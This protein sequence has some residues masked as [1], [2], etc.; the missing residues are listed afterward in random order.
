MKK[1]IIWC[2]IAVVQASAMIVPI[3]AYAQTSTAYSGLAAINQIIQGAY[4][5]AATSVAGSTSVSA[6]AAEYVSL[7]NGMR[8]PVPV[9]ATSAV[10]AGR[11]A[12][13][14]ATAMKLGTAVGIA[15]IVLPWIA[16]KYGIT[17]CP[18]P[19]FFCKPG[20]GTEI[21]P[22]NTGRYQRSG[23][24]ATGACATYYNT[25]QASC[26]AVLASLP[27][28]Q[29]T[30][31]SPVVGSDNASGTQ[32][33]CRT[34]YGNSWYGNITAPTCPVGAT[35]LNGKCMSAG[36][37][38][39]ATEGDLTTDLT[40]FAATDATRQQSLYGS[41]RAN[42]LPVI[43]PADPVTVSAP[44]V[45]LP[46][47]V[48]TETVPN[49]DGSTSTK[50][51]TT[52]TTVNP[53][54]TGTTVNN[55]TISYPTTTTTTTNI[56]N[57]TTN[58]T[59]ITNVTKTETATPPEK[60]APPIP[61]P[62]VDPVKDF[63]QTNPTLT[64]CK[65]STVSGT[66]K[67]ITCTGDAI[68]CAVAQQVAESNCRAL[69]EIDEIKARSDYA[70]GNTVLAGG[71]DPLAGVPTRANGTTV[72]ASSIDQS[73]WLGGGACFPDKD[74]TIQGKTVTIP[75]HKVCEY[76]VAFRVVVMMVGLIGAAR[77][78]AGAVIRE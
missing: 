4:S 67:E 28:D 61:K 23:S 8:I 38:V 42:G 36:L 63:C 6:A 60:P 37:P 32:Y 46:P 5:A 17:V 49:T 73:G 7:S 52:T 2:L 13:V 31:Y 16:T 59:T 14:A 24:C 27:A 72:N 20:P 10:A 44:S 40:D 15:S 12:G 48:V 69:K 19:D 55:T 70:L 9:T 77:I 58:T 3:S 65:T 25:S 57:N 21:S 53:V 11:L 30:S 56:K 41:V 62:V 22:T 74:F 75:F 43:Q 35:V 78:L 71:P 26:D 18:P 33:N 64:V 51:T 47:Q 68:N 29:R 76:L 39:S 45:Q 54:V 66:C 34:P 1:F 50:T